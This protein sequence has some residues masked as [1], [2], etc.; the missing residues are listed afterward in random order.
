MATNSFMNVSM[1]SYM[2]TVITEVSIHCMKYIT[3]IIT[4]VTLKNE[5]IILFKLFCPRIVM[6]VCYLIF[7]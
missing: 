7:S 2:L 3:I 6:V 4:L 5:D 1:M